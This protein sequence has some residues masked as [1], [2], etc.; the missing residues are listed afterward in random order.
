MR[1]ILLWVLL[2]LLPTVSAQYVVVARDEGNGFGYRFEDEAGQPFVLSMRPGSE[3]TLEL[4]NEGTQRHGLRLL[5]NSTPL[6]SPGNVTQLTFTVPQDE[7]TLECP[8]HASLGMT[9]PVRPAGSAEKST[10]L[11]LVVA[12][13]ALLTATYAKAYAGRASRRR[14]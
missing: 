12:F 14:P 1:P 6:V 9:A 13:G 10:P 4:R 3:V 7:A 11:P 2:L 8:A 5:G